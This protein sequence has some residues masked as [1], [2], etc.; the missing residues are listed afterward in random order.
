MKWEVKKLENGLWGIM[1]CEKYW[2][3]K[4]KPVC[5]AASRTKAGAQSRVDRL[6]ESEGK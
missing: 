1:L 4:D 6:N 5:Y 3:F 2:K